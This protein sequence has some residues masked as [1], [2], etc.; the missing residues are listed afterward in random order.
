MHIIHVPHIFVGF[1]NDE[2]RIPVGGEKLD[3]GL[4]GYQLWPPFPCLVERIRELAV[5]CE[6]N[7]MSLYPVFYRA[8]I[9]LLLPLF[10]LFSTI[11]GDRT[12][13]T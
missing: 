5:A 3:N 7:E 2:V 13:A 8:I 1:E 11:A 12:P 10:L 4:L 9:L 6:I